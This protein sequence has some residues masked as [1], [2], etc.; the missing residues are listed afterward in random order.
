MK[1]PNELRYNYKLYTFSPVRPA[2]ISE[3]TVRSQF[4]AYFSFTALSNALAGFHPRGGQRQHATECDWSY[5]DY[6]C[7]QTPGRPCRL[8]SP[9]FPGVYPAHLSCRYA[10]ATS[11][12]QTRVRIAFSAL[13]LPHDHCATHHIAV[14]A[15][16][17][18]EPAKR[19][20]TVCGD[21]R[22]APV[23]LTFD[24][25]NVLIE[26]N[27]GAQVPPFDYN[28][29]AATLEFVEARDETEQ[30]GPAEPPAPVTTARA[31]TPPKTT[32]PAS[33][34]TTARQ[35]LT[36]SAAFG[37]KSGFVAQV[38]PVTPRTQLTDV[39]HRPAELCEC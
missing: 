17:A 12:M 34:V 32:A 2:S 31:K 1:C 7:Q 4:L 11:S 18:P 23:D 29:F 19:L 25:P 30:A 15:G 21:R 14:Y 28:G 39:L 24:G 8:A 37:Y 38:P 9:G 13:L 22:P 10:V 27:A 35:Q 26:F 16:I 3:P 6:A 33:A 20:V 5:N 36:Q